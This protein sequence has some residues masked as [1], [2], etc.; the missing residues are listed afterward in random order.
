MECLLADYK[1]TA[2]ERL[3]E[4]FKGK[5]NLKGFIEAFIDDDAQIALCE[6]LTKRG[7]ETSIGKQ[8]DGIGEIVGRVRPRDV[9][10]QTATFGF[11]EDFNALTFTTLD[12][13][14]VGGYQYT[15]NPPLIAPVNDDIYRLFIKAKIFQN[16]T[17]MTVDETLNIL[18]AIFDANI[19]YFLVDSLRPM[20]EIGKTFN[21][22][23]KEIIKSL[24]QTIGISEVQYKTFLLGSAFGFAEDP[25]ALGFTA[26]A[27][28]TIGGNLASLI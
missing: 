11:E 23:E 16:S 26:L 5:P 6:L 2:Q 18:S 9:L 21:S 27:D 10:D 20:Y 24:P 25:A 3:A 7:L 15:L 12:D 14:Q 28:N 17:N 22:F 19:R 4:Q 13:N 1:I 8:L